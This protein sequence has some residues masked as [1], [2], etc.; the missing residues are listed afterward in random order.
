[1]DTADI[2]EIHWAVESI[3]NTKA[4]NRACRRPYLA[5]YMEMLLNCEDKT[6]QDNHKGVDS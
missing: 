1:M 6:I 5:D 4:G 2:E 3:W